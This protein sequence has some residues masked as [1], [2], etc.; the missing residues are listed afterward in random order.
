[1]F[2]ILIVLLLGLQYR[3]WVGDGSLSEIV[4]L[5][6]ELKQQQGQVNQLL[7]RN[8]KLELRVIELQSGYAATEKIARKELGMIKKDETFF[9]IIQRQRDSVESR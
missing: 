6:A 1:M 4:Q 8:R 9:Q 7:K 5:K 3:L 2:V